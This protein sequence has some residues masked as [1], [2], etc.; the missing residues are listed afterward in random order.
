[1]SFPSYWLFIAALFA[2]S[3]F[4]NAKAR[5]GKMEKSNKDKLQLEACQAVKAKIASLEQGGLPPDVADQFFKAYGLERGEAHAQ[6]FAKDVN[7]CNTACY[8]FTPQNPKACVM[9]VH[10]YLDHAMAWRKIVPQLLKGGYMVL[11][12]DLPGHGFSD[13]ARADIGDFGEYR[14]QLAHMAEFAGGYGLRLHVIAHS[15]GAGILADLLLHDKE[16]AEKLASAVLIAP[17]LHSAHWEISRIGVEFWPGKSVGRKF[18]ENSSDPSFKDF[19]KADPLQ[20]DSIP[21]SWTKANET[22]AKRMLDSDSV[23]GGD[24]V[25]FIQGKKDK[26]VDWKFNI[27]VYRRKFPKATVSMYEEGQHQLMNESPRMLDSLTDEIL[28]WLEKE[29]EGR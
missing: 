9:L 11:L 25:L 26:V 2:L 1:M 27:D 20:Y 13:G 23:Y 12:Y 24:N 15:T 29:Q 18:R 28:K 22:W 4:A 17:L 19:Q 10:G 5:G 16:H 21:L 14:E 8:V 3:L 6:V 7:N